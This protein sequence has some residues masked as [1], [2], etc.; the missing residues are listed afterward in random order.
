MCSSEGGVVL[1]L[2]HLIMLYVDNFDNYIPVKVLLFWYFY[3][4]M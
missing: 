1:S 4:I 2:R 3:V